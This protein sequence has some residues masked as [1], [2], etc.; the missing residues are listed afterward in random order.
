M[1]DSSPVTSNASRVIRASPETIYAAFLDPMLLVQWLPPAGMTGRIHTF[2][3]RVGGGYRMSLYYPATE[4]GTR[5]KTSE[6]EDMVDVRFVELR[7]AERIVEAVRFVSDDPAFGGE[8]SMTITLDP[9]PAGTS[10]RLAFAN[11]PSGLRPEDNDLG[12]QSSLAQL[13]H[14]LEIE[15]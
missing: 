15:R 8:M 11:L 5:G 1:T 7:P 3:A 9:V 10:V 14:L 6:R 12:A 13:A 4:V 2:D